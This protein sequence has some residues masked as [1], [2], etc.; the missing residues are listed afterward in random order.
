MMTQK[1]LDAI[2]GITIRLHESA[3]FKQ[4]NLTRD[5]VQEWVAQSLA[6]SCDIYT[7]PVGASWGVKVT[8]K[9]YDE[10][11]NKNGTL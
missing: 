1:E 9:E 8:K 3:F 11:W 6:D 4:K 10:Y 5:R 7:I 2:F